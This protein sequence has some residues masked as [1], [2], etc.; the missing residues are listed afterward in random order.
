MRRLSRL[1]VLLV[2]TAAAPAAAAMDNEALQHSFLEAMQRV[3][4][5][6][7]ERAESILRSM[8]KH[9]RT[10]RVT[11]ELAR[12]L[13]LRG[14]YRESKALF[15][16]VMTRTETPWRVRDNIAGYI[17]DI[18][19]RV[20]YLKLGSTFVSDSNPRN[21]PPQKEVAIG[22]LQLTP[23]EAPKNLTGS[24]YTVEGW[25]PVNRPFRGGGY[26]NASL[27]DYSGDESDGIT[28]DVGVLR[29][30]SE[31]GRVRAKAGFEL[32]TLGG[33]Q[34]YQLPYVGVDSVLSE[35][36]SS[37]VTAEAKL[38]RVNVPDAGY[39]DATTATA[40][41]TWRKTLSPAAVTSLNGSIEFSDAEERAYSYHGWE[42]SPGID[43]FSER[44]L[45]LVGARVAVGARSYHDTD[46]LFGARRSDR[47]YKL[48]VSLGHK[49]WRWQNHYVALRASLERTDSSIGFYS[50]NR[51]NV[52]VVME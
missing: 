52:S 13:Y 26:L 28:A 12:T 17:R 15:E 18:E 23:T 25:L 10:P 37:R 5:G 51:F 45:F 31:D 27:T 14:K 19:K 41:A 29:E 34:L 16:D 7:L 44:S 9:T 22:N 43:L 39:L 38:G 42:L 11:L 6:D 24:R 48:E 36:E 49:R 20:G 33:R 3:E 32:G 35:N 47:R 40:A 50:Y 30:I 1:V 2:A 4:A 21:L 8:L 46:P